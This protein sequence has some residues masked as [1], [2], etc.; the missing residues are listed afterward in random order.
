L[1]ADVIADGVETRAQATFLFA[2]GCE[3]AQGPFFAPVLSAAEATMLL[4]H[5][6]AA[7][8]MQ[9]STSPSAA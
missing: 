1:G 2:A 8:A 7:A 9:T 4:R 3:Q 5:A 6:P